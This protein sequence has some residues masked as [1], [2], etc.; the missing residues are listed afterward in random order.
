MGIWGI[1]GTFP[2]GIV[3]E[4]I[5]KSDPYEMASKWT[6]DKVNDIYFWYKEGIKEG[7]KP[8]TN[9]EKQIASFIS[10]HT[11]FSIGDTNLFGWSLQQLAVAGE[12]KNEYY[13]I[14]IPSTAQLPD[15][16]FIP[17]QT[18]LLQYAKTIKWLAI[19]GIVGVVVYFTY[20][21]LSKG[22]KQ[23]KKRMA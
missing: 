12:I 14:E 17:S 16:P 21:V 9:E 13:T 20:P 18:Q 23:L 10:E 8:W 3:L 1:P 19:A 22:R 2:T 11:S 4:R 5:K 7:H 6:R 15:I